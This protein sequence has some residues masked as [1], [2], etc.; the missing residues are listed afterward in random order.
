MLTV[1]VNVYAQQ[2]WF[3]TAVSGSRNSF[4][5]TLLAQLE[6]KG[7]VQSNENPHIIIFWMSQ[8]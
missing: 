1:Y 8:G 5:L 6:E 3:S 4:M 7:Y 2:F